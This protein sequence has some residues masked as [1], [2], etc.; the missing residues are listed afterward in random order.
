MNKTQA[1][2][3]LRT[4]LQE[5]G[6]ND[7]AHLERTNTVVKTF[8]EEAAWWRTNHL[9]ILKASSQETMGSHIDKYLLPRFGKMPVSAVDERRVQEFIADLIPMEHVW[10]SGKSRRISAKTIHNI[11]GVLKSI[12]GKKATRDWNLRLPE[13]PERDQRYL[14]P[15]EMRQVVNAAKGQWKV[16]FAFYA[17]TGT[18]CGESSGLRVED[19]DLPF[20]KV[21]VRRGIYKGK[22]ITTKTK[23]GKRVID[24]D[25]EL[26]EML[27]AHLHG[28]TTG[29]VF[30]TQNGTP[31]CKSNVRRKLNEILK[32]LNLAPA[33]TH[34]F[35]HGRVSVLQSNGVPGDLIRQWVGHS[36]LRT[37]SIYTHF[38]D[39]FSQGIASRLGLFAQGTTAKEMPVGPNGP[40]LAEIAASA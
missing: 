21:C 10:P 25:P 36:N 24:I 40:K 1:K 7:E 22:E 9:S 6:L 18:R 16:M 19:L 39:D 2:R 20:L 34:A 11:V 30:P 27:K 13:I 35:R 23:K 5:M 38:Q 3:K 12:M 37:T 15:E 32:K 8:N 14:T 17:G 33:G 28:R 29:Y 4:E 31:Y 26:G